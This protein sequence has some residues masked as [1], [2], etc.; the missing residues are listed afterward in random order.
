LALDVL[1]EPEG[2]MAK[3]K[4][5]ASKSAGRFEQVM[6][7]AAEDLGAFFGTVTRRVETWVRERDRLAKQLKQIQGTAGQLLGRLGTVGENPFLFSD[8]AGRRGTQGKRR[9]STRANAATRGRKK[10]RFS[11]A[12]R[13]RMAAAQRARWAKVKGAKQKE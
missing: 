7:G 9:G 11:A 10:R 5:N 6:M 4:A 12:T 3:R 1:F 8:R 2:M 13:R